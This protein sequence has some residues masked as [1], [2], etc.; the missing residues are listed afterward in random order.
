MQRI[1]GNAKQAEIAAFG[2]VHLGAQAT[3]NLVSTESQKPDIQQRH[4]EG[5]AR[6]PQ[7]MLQGGALQVKAI[8]FKA[9]ISR[10]DPHP[11]LVQAQDKPGLV[12][13]VANSQGVG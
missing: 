5:E 1:P 4:G 3:L 10:L 7:E 8:V 11:P 2:T 13:L 6:Q 9:P 12:K